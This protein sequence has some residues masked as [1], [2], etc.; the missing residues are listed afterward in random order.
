MWIE[1]IINLLLNTGVNILLLAFL[2]YFWFKYLNTRF[3]EEWVKKARKINNDIEEAET[4]E[5]KERI[6][7]IQQYLEDHKEE[8]RKEWIDRCSLFLMHNW[9]RSGEFHYMYY[10]LVAEVQADWLE[11]FANH[12]VN[13]G[14]IP[15]FTMINYE[16]KIKEWGGSWFSRDLK[17]LW[18][19]AQQI[20]KQLWTKSLYIRGIYDL[21][22]E[23]IGIM[24]I[25]SVFTQMNERPNCKKCVD[26]VRALLIQ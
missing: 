10:S 7:K 18:P 8:L 13:M 1:T 2:F 15:F 25:S 20:A 17:D 23:Y 6:R 21:E 12:K 24:F 16:D 22:W 3:F 9:T 19:T 4:E 26:N 11:S 14:R 5:S